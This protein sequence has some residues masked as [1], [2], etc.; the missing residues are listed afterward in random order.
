MLE[1]HE[2]HGVG[3]TAILTS[4]NAGLS[5]SRPDDPLI[6]QHRECV[7]RGSDNAGAA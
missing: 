5:I 4:G 6:A 7:P 3:L 2:A 1:A